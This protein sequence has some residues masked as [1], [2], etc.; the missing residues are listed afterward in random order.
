MALAGEVKHPEIESEQEIES[1]GVLAKLSRA[2][3]DTQIATAKQWPRSIKEFKRSA[4][5]LATLDQDTA[6]SMYYTLPRAGRTIEGPS[7]RFA[8]VIGS[9]WKNLRYGSRIVDIED[10]FIVAQGMAFDLESN[11]AATIEVRRRITDRNGRRYNEDMITVTGNAAC[12][13]ALRNAIFKVVPFALAKSVYEEA[14]KVSLGKGMTIE[15]QRDKA[16]RALAKYGAKP[17]D[18]YRVVKRK[19]IDDLTIDDLIVLQ[20]IETALEE[21]DSTWDS[22]LAEAG[23]TDEE[24]RESMKT[25]LDKVADAIPGSDADEKVGEPELTSIKDLGEA[26][27]LHPNKILK[28]AQKAPFGVKAITDLTKAQVGPFLKALEEAAGV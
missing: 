8:E 11:L 27:E 19:G 12:S 15:Q 16:V 28:L 25:N 26:L 5:E 20:G 7:V 4:L 13:I 23:K 3:L 9:A 18:V 14:K 17:A 6:R 21:G 2:E 10:Q 22:I 1:S 24:V